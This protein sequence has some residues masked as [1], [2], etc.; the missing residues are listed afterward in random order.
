[1]TTIYF[2]VV[3]LVII[4]KNTYSKIEVLPGKFP[5]INNCG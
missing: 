3:F 5:V 1:M 2:V 4:R